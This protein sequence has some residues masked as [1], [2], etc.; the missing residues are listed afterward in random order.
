MATFTS[1]DLIAGAWQ[2][3]NASRLCLKSHDSRISHGLPVAFTL[4]ELL[5]S[6]AIIAILASLVLASIASTKE[7]SKRAVCMSNL[8]QIGIGMSLYAEDN[9]GYY[10][11]AKR[12]VP[13]KA[14]IDVT[15]VQIALEPLAAKAAGEVNLEVNSTTSKIWTCPSRPKLPVYEE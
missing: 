12:D 8:R 1:C 9:N 3:R 13:D 2:R 7:K 15:F 5:V 14:D 10:L 4:I 11:S 6:I